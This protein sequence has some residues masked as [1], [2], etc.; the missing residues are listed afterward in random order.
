M[1]KSKL[2]RKFSILHPGFWGIGMAM[3]LINV[4]TTPVYTTLITWSIA[5]MFQSFKSPLP[6]AAS[7]EEGEKLWNKDFFHKDVL[8][9]SE[10]IT[11]DN[12]IDHWLFLC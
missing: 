1:I 11:C 2:D 7:T 12:T 5:F 8:H 4:L 3:V 9:K 6:W 10:C